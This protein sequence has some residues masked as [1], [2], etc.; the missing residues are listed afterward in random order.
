MEALGP[1]SAASFSVAATQDAPRRP[2]RHALRVAGFL[3]L[4]VGWLATSLA[5]TP[6]ASASAD[7]TDPC[8]ALNPFTNDWVDGFMS[9]IGGVH[10]AGAVLDVASGCSSRFGA[11]DSFPTASTVKAEIM[12]AVFLSLQDQ[13]I[14]TL[15]ASTD[16]LI[17]AMI[18]ESDNTSAS[19]LY[20]GLGGS[21]AL[22]AYGRRLG[23]VTTDNADFAWGDDATSPDDQLR[24]LQT[25]LVGG[26]ALS[27]A[28]VAQ[29]RHYMGSI[30]PSEDWG[31][32]SGAPT[33][34]TV[35]LKN[36]WLFND[37]SIIGRVG[38]WRI[39]SIGAVRLPNGR[40]YVIAV[41]GDEWSTMEDGQN[42]IATVSARV[43][44]TLNAPRNE[45]STL[46]LLAA[47][48]KDTGA[49]YTAISPTRVLDTRASGGALS[50]NGDVAVDVARGGPL[51][52]AVAVNITAVDATSDGYVT[53]WPDGA[54]RPLASTLNQQPGRAVANFAIVPVGTDGRIR[55]YT[56]A[57]VDLAVDLLG[58]WAPHPGA[59]TAGRYEAVTPARLADTRTTGAPL[60]PGATT[61][62]TVAGHGGVPAKGAAAAVLNV[63]VTAST[64]AGYWTAWPSGT[65]RP[66]ASTLNTNSGDTIANATII[67]IAADGTISIYTQ[68][69][70][71]VIVD[72]TGWI[73]DNT[74]P[75]ATT[76]RFVPLAVPDRVVDTRF[77]V[78]GVDRLTTGST[79]AVGVLVPPTATAVAAVLT[80]TTPG[81][82]GFLTVYAPNATQPTASSANPTVALGT[83]ANSI[84]TGVINDQLE[85]YSQQSTDLV[86][87]V[88]GWFTP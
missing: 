83:W 78:G 39:N 45:H 17:S 84:V 85:I 16:A 64:G 26:G 58:T 50:A 6:A 80:N 24:L 23:M 77:G 7:T 76:G 19:A 5:V 82:D 70:G 32:N 79:S 30:T 9:S 72:V 41:Y 66:V 35:W 38:Y 11:T 44:T 63:T 10:V 13:G 59:A 54:P 21:G 40:I 88:S 75:S 68:S 1:S 36:G 61:T 3:I 74:A 56:S 73:T 12:G 53:A 28:W 37:G 55:F 87:D 29:A 42:A 31:V 65:R 22:Q 81:A 57:P 71:H 47:P 67:P 43:A 51:P 46:T 52:S 25:L 60:A 69:G 8:A 49:V 20:D 27:P 34:S 4:V 33:G 18:E 14:T 15:D 86:V 2:S 48:T 62:V